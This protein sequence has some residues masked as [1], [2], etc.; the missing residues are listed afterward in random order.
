M[1][2]ELGSLLM[3][4]LEVEVLASRLYTHAHT[5]PYPQHEQHTKEAIR[6]TRCI[7]I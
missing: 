1:E 5:L 4:K 7:Q 2:G 3:A 6:C